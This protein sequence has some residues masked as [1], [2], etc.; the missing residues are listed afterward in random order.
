M[1]DKPATPFGEALRRAQTAR[2]TA[3][4]VGDQIRAEEAQRAA[5][6]AERGSEE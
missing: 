5:E 6:A 3:R 4:G 1:V 2:D